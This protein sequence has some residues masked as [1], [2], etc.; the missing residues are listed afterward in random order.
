MVTAGNPVL[1]ADMNIAQLERIGQNTATTNTATITTTETA[2][3]TVTVSLVS[4]YRYAIRWWAPALMSVAADVFY[5]RI[6]EG[7]GT[8]GTQ[9][10]YS[11]A[12][13]PDAGAQVYPIEVYAEYVA[14]A[15]G[16][17]TFTG[18][19]IRNTGTG[20]ISLRGSSTQGRYLTVDYLSGA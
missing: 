20:N 9:L 16:S 12:K 1:A 11:S 17:Q 10:S 3:D 19:A 2:V 14:S 6:R 18:T 8:G 13:A 5:L 4:G 7:S 15:T